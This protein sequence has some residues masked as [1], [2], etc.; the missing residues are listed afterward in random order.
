VTEVEHLVQPSVP[1]GQAIAMR[2][3]EP[4]PELRASNA[5]RV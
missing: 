3:A 4:R 1:V 2:D 5:P